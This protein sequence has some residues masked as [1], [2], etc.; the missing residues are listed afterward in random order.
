MPKPT[1]VQLNNVTLAS[2]VPSVTFSNIPGTYRDLILVSRNSAT[3]A[4]SIF[5]R[6]NNNTSD[7]T[8]VRIYNSGNSPIS[9]TWAPAEIGFNTTNNIGIAQIMDYSAIDKHKTYLTRWG[10]A[11]GTP[12]VQA[13]AARWASTDAITS[14]N[15]VVGSGSIASGSTFTLYGIEA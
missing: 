2:S 3:V 5:L 7:Y 12:Y 15:I 9:D 14:V 10:N 4:D 6:F 13:Y 8:A 11:D 1:Y